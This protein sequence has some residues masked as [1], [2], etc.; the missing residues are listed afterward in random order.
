MKAGSVTRVKGMKNVMNNLNREIANIKGASMQ[1]LMRVSIAIKNDTET[2]KPK[3]PVDTG[4]LRASW[5]VYPIKVLTGANIMF[6][7]TAN[8]AEYVHENVGAQF[9]GR[10]PSTSSRGS[11]FPGGR[12]DSGA[13]FFESSIKKLTP[14]IVRILQTSINNRV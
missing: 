3:T 13:K 1:G 6:G 5:R 7:F 12:P 8:Y 4:N 2:S 14:E 10:D 11:K 9:Y